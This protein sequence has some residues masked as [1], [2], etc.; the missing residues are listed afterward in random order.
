MTHTVAIAFTFTLSLFCLDI[1]AVGLDRGAKVYA[2]RCVL[3]HGNT[4][5]GDGYLPLRINDYPE[6]NLF[7][8]IKAASRKQVI[9]VVTK[10]V[11]QNMPPWEDELS[12]LEIADVADLII[13]LRE[14]TESAVAMLNK[15]TSKLLRSLE[16]G[17][18][19]FETR[20]SLCHG[21]GGKGDGRLSKLITQPSPANLTQ[22][23][24]LRAS[25]FDIITLGGQAVG[26]SSKM[27]PWGEVLSVNEI[28]AVTDY[29]KTLRD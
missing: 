24:L 2:E 28:N 27:P 22:S 12:L 25:M 5:T 4:G 8:K 10:G 6:T 26:R 21:M 3:C 11:N 16:E 18:V 20:C 14:D 13:Y 19:I 17:K 29:V 9:S 7:I 15:Y 23:R 1:Y